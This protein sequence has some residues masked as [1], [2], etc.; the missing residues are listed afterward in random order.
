MK[1][2]PKE[3]DVLHLC[4]TDREVKDSEQTIMKKKG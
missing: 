3:T 4:M 2:D 1:I